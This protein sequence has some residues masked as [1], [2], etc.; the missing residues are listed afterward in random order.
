MKGGYYNDWGGGLS[1]IMGKLTQ[2]EKILYILPGGNKEVDKNLS[3]N[4]VAQEGREEGI[5]DVRWIFKRGRNDSFW[6]PD[7]LEDNLRKI[8][9]ASR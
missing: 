1:G 6:K 8:C 5:E 2:Q 7:T 3:F 9:L 4:N